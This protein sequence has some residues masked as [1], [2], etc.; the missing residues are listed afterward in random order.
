[1]TL[2]AKLTKSQ[3]TE[4]QNSPAHIAP[5]KESFVKLAITHSPQFLGL[6]HKNGL[7]PTASYGAGEIIGVVDTGIWPESESFNDDA[8][9]K[10]IHETSSSDK[11]RTTV[12]ILA[13]IEAAITDGVD[14]LS[15]SIGGEP[16]DYFTDPM[17]IG[18]A[19]AIFVVSAFGTN[20]NLS[21]SPF[22]KTQN[23]APWITTVGATTVDRSFEVVL[24]LKNGNTV[25]GISYFP[26]SIFISNTSLYFGRSSGAKS[27]CSPDSL[28]PR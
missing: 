6:N 3:L 11:G 13:A 10:V 7:W 28:N 27:I 26:Q 21:E 1:M 18:S 8:S 9:N 24:K 23:G 16:D 5:H 4:I 20:D 17:S 15:M 2:P 14:I 12:N 22:N 25:K 19:K